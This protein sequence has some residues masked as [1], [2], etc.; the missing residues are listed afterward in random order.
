M[1]YFMFHLVSVH[2]CI[3]VEEDSEL[4]PKEYCYF[5]TNVAGMAI[6]SPEECPIDYVGEEVDVCY[7]CN[8]NYVYYQYLFI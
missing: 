7:Q 5:M 3:F 4:D 1:F 2:S 6:C 8:N